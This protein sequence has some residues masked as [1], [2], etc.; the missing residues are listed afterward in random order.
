MRFFKVVKYDIKNGLLVSPKRWI[1]LIAYILF[2]CVDFSLS[3]FHIYFFD[4]DSVFDIH[5]LPLSLGDLILYQLGG[6][7]PRFEDSF[8]IPTAWFLFHGGLCYMTLSYPSEDLSAGGIQVMIRIKRK[9][10]WWFSK[11]L[12]NFLMTFCYHAISYLVMFLF[13][14][15]TGLDLSFTLNKEL[16]AAKYGWTLPIQGTQRELLLGM[17]VLPFLASAVIS[18]MQMTISLFVRPVFAFTIS[19]IYLLLGAY[20]TFPFLLS[21][22]AMPVRSAVIGVY[23]FTFRSGIVLCGIIG[24]GSILI[25]A[26]STTK[27]DIMPSTMGHG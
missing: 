19:A 12:W 27:R 11:C 8:M 16:F 10:L 4:L 21:N 3:A 6:M 13:C 7:I 26:L 24:A 5:T 22:D 14:G 15:F 1:L 9:I 23:D 25:G 20:F 2:L 17:M 18:L